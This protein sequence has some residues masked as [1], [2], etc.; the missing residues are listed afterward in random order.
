MT[1]LY[2][3]SFQTSKGHVTWIIKKVNTIPMHCGV[4]YESLLSLARGHVI[5]VSKYVNN[6]QV[7]QFLGNTPPPSP[8]YPLR[9]RVQSGNANGITIQQKTFTNLPHVLLWFCLPPFFPAGNSLP[10][11]TTYLE[12]TIIVQL[13]SQTD[14][15]TFCI[16]LACTGLTYEIY[17]AGGSYVYIFWRFFYIHILVVPL[18]TY[19][20]GSTTYL[21]IYCVA[22]FCMI[23]VP[24]VICACFVFEVLYTL[25][26]RWLFYTTEVYFYL[27]KLNLKW[28]CQ[29][30]AGS[31]TVLYEQ[32]GTASH[33]VLNIW[34]TSQMMI[35]K[36]QLQAIQ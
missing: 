28:K 30:P 22:C 32:S 7:K 24:C 34:T 9:K 16:I 25:V 14:D 8:T 26:S 5:R 6:L 10:A 2:S 31:I 29:L 20:G 15:S 4:A 35:Y 23:T 12:G 17:R 27:R 3:Y 36:F 11:G 1:L 18:H 19:I 13:T 33:L 21:Y